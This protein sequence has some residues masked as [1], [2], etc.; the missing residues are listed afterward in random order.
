MDGPLND[1][2]EGCFRGGKAGGLETGD[3]SGSV[4]KVISGLCVG[5]ALTRMSDESET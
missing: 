1:W 5:S 2:I 4:S 3:G